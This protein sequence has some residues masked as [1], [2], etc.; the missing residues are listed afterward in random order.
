MRLKYII[1]FLLLSLLIA[2]CTKENEPIQPT[3][4]IEDCLVDEFYARMLINGKC[5]TSNFAYFIIQDS[6]LNVGMRKDVIFYEEEFALRFDSLKLNHKFT[7]KGDRNS[8]VSFSVSRSFDTLLTYYEPRYSS[9]KE[10][11]WF[12]IDSI[13]SDSTV[14]KGKFEAV[15]YR[16]YSPVIDSIYPRP[17]KLVITNGQFKVERIDID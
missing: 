3:D 9:E 2:S 14:I 10:L 15:L 13:N 11:N 16:E 17:E 1:K 12:L 8:Q 5:W 7:L 4:T 6:I